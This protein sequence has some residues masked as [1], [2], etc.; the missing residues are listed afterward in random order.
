[1]GLISAAGKTILPAA[2]HGMAGNIDLPTARFKR[3]PAPD[4]VAGAIFAADA[5]EG[6]SGKPYDVYVG[7]SINREEPP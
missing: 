3:S 5:Q 7:Q 4:F 6:F 1:M 2:P